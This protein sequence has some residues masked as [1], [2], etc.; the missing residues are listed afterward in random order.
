MNFTVEEN[1]IIANALFAWALNYNRHKKIAVEE[2]LSSN[3]VNYLQRQ[4]QITLELGKH[5]TNQLP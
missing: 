2:K 5:F 4:E 3:V 1:T